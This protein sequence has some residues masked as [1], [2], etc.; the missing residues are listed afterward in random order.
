MKA[1]QEVMEPIYYKLKDVEALRY[2]AVLRRIEIYETQ[3][4][5][6]YKKCQKLGQL[7]GTRDKGIV[8]MT[9]QEGISWSWAEPLTNKAVLCTPQD[10]LPLLINEPLN[11]DAHITLK[12]RLSGEIKGIPHCQELIDKYF[13][14]DK[15]LSNINCI[16][17]RNNQII[18]RYV[19]H[20][21]YELYPKFYHQDPSLIVRFTINDRTYLCQPFNQSHVI[22]LPPET[23][24]KEISEQDVLQDESLSPACHGYKAWR[25]DGKTVPIH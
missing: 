11:E 23:E 1:I 15:R 20:K 9:A 19:T 4:L 14:Y 18:E 16:I 7:W 2:K 3:W 25:C 5:P 17:G 13:L 22:T 12:K 24:I 6:T 21:A 8:L 10:Q